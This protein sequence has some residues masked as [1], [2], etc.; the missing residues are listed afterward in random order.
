[1]NQNQERKCDGPVLP[2]VERSDAGQV[3]GHDD[4]IGGAHQEG[5]GPVPPSALKSPEVAESGAGPTVEAAF[6][7]H[8]GRHFRSRQRNRNAEKKRNGKQKY[9]GHSR[10]GGGDD[11]LEAKRPA[12]AI[13]VEDGHEWRQRDLL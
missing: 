11:G 5:T 1:R 2:S 6:Y 13:R 4:S 7:R 12:R 8:G 10:P 9:Q 3:I